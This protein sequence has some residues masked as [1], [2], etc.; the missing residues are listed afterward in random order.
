M[1]SALRSPGIPTIQ[2]SNPPKKGSIAG[3]ITHIAKGDN[4]LFQALSS[5]QQ[6]TNTIVGNTTPWTTWNPN[7]TDSSNIPLLYSNFSAYYMTLGAL[8]IFQIVYYSLILPSPS[9]I[10]LM[11]I[12]TALPVDIGPALVKTCPAYLVQD[13][14]P[15]VNGVSAVQA[16][17]RTLAISFDPGFSGSSCT[18]IAGGVMGII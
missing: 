10:T 5:L 3:L 8:F 4:H 16:I 18:L 17:S 2:P 11:Y 15:V 7:F 9:N 1:S 12:Q 6:Q 14:Q 13:L